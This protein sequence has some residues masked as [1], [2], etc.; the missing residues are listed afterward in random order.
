MGPFDAVVQLQHL[1]LTVLPIAL[2][3]GIGTTI[4]GLLASDRLPPIYNAVIA[5]VTIGIFAIL[6]VFASGKL[7]G[8]YSYDFTLLVASATVL[9]SAGLS[10]LKHYL[11]SNFGFGVTKDP[12][13]S[14][15][16]PTLNSAVDKQ[17]T[18][19]A[20][21]TQ[22]ASLRYQQYANQQTESSTPLQTQSPVPPRASRVASD[23][24]SGGILAC[25]CAST[26][27]SCNQLRHKNIMGR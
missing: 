19:P 10:P 24:T 20:L 13:A 23:L 6:S 1:L 17:Q 4:N 27:I 21:M 2:S 22:T 16:V 18:I 5:Y 14:R 7:T 25:V 11:Q 15:A 9:M 12:L 26:T 8:D 3:S